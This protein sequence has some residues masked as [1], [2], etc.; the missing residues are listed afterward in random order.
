MRRP[1]STYLMWHRYSLNGLAAAQYL[2]CL[3][4]G[5]LYFVVFGGVAG[6]AAGAS[7]VGLGAVFVPLVLGGYASALSLL[8]PRV[9]AVVAL[10]CSVPYLLLGFLGHLRGTILFFVIPSTVVIA[11]SIV[12]LLFSEGSVWRRLT[13]TF[14]KIAIGIILTLPALLATWCFG[15]FTRALL[16]V[17][18]HRTT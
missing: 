3:I 15:S 2:S 13:T 16:S 12:A 1:R 4:V 6:V 10:T 9:A 8:A 5:A 18:W 7:L 11:I 14:Q 17:Y